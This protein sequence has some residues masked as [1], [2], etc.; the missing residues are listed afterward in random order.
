MTGQQYLWQILDV[1]SFNIVSMYILY[2]DVV[3][4]LFEL[5]QCISLYS[6]VMSWI[7]SCFES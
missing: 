6:D 1:V 7:L 2:S 5:Y 3:Y 4:K